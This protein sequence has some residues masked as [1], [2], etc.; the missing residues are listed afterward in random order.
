M[1][2]DEFELD[3]ISS[4]IKTKF[5]GFRF[6]Y[7]RNDRF[8]TMVDGLRLAKDN[9]DLPALE[10][11]LKNVSDDGEVFEVPADK[12]THLEKVCAVQKVLLD[13]FQALNESLDEEDPI[14]VQRLRRRTIELTERHKLILESSP[15]ICR[16]GVVGGVPVDDHKLLVQ[17]LVKRTEE[18]SF[19][20]GPLNLS[21]F[22]ETRVRDHN[23]SMNQNLAK[24]V[25][26][27]LDGVGLSSAG[28]NYVQDALV[29]PTD[30][31]QVSIILANYTFY[32]ELSTRLDNSI[33]K[34][35]IFD[36]FFWK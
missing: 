21:M 9:I 29:V 27:N 33:N 32:L 14:L 4:K 8:Q 2:P 1:L 16:P 7:E 25:F 3:T 35:L 5:S 10:E 12:N 18:V 22:G 11:L 20:S 17:N 28:A 23:H 15:A 6:N 19:L 34:I 31:V 36:E 26:D 30:H 24:P 13:S